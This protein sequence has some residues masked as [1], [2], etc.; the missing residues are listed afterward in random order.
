[1]IGSS[2]NIITKVFSGSG[3]KFCD[4]PYS[5]MY[6]DYRGDVLIILFAIVVQK[7]LVI[8]YLI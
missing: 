1:M 8:I 2:H 4:L 3:G 5:S 6:V 7:S